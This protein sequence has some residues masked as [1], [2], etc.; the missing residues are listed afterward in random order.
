MSGQP[1]TLA[2][3]KTL[4]S[5]DPETGVFTR[6]GFRKGRGRAGSKAGTFDDDGYVIVCVDYKSYRAN[7]LAWF[8]LFGVW[9][10]G[11][12]DHINGDRSD[13]RWCNLR[14]ISNQENSQNRH[15][16]NA[17]RVRQLPIGVYSSGS[18]FK[19]RIRVGGVNHHLG[20]F[21]T[22]ELASAAYLSCRRLFMAGNTL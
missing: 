19:S 6:V 3:L 21:D 9:P 20:R 1:L 5:Y 22:P 12:I 16:P 4:I 18:G 8:Y 14:E 2:R 15:G 11:S 17:G 10:D 7:R 13:D